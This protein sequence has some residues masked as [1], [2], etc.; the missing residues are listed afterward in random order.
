M[1]LAADYPF[2]DILWSMIVFAFFVMFVWIVIMVLMDNFRR[3]D[4]G[5]WA[6]ALWTLFIV[7][8]PVLGVLIYMIVRPRMTEQDQQ[9][10]AAA[11][12]Q[13]AAYD[14][15]MAP[16]A[17][18][19]ADEVAKLHKLKDSGALTDEEFAAAKAKALA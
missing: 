4:H 19:A 9:L 17:N 15:R 6:K 16:P 7:F 8:L 3:N 2:L 1:L 5:G 12:A 18:S 13:R 11:D 10:L 14:A